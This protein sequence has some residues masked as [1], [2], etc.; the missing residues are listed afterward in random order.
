MING[1]LGNFPLAAGAGYNPN[2]GA[3][4]IDFFDARGNTYNQGYFQLLRRNVEGGNRQSD[5]SHT[6]YR[7]VLG[8]RGDLSNVFSYDAYHQYGRTQY[9]QVYRT[10]SR[11]PACATR[12]MS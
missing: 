8:T 5:L 9:Q 7:G 3:P 11:F 1:F 4:P 2:P 12:S 6:S 10:S